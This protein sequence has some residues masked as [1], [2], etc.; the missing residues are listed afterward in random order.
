MAT[1]FPKFKIDIRYNSLDYG[2]FSFDFTDACPTDITVSDVTLRSFV[3]S[4]DIDDDLDDF[5]ESTDELIDAAKTVVTGS[6]TVNA[7]FN[8][9]T[10]AAYQGTRHS[11]V[12]EITFSNEGTHNFYGRSIWV[13]EATS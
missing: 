13:R 1:D 11:L 6:Y 10:T 9:P 7:Y 2:P 3:G 4:V 12:F 5:T 8:F